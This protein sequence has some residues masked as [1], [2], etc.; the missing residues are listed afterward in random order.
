MN[1][2]TKREIE[3]MKFSCLPNKEIG[4]KL[5]ISPKTVQTHITNIRQKIGATSRQSTIIE[6]LK[7]KIVNIED[8]I[9]N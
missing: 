1:D 5:F 6:L 2:F 3:V 9:T 4:E 8:I 7:T